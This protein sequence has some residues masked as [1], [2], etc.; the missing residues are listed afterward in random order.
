MERRHKALALGA[1]LAAG[2]VLGVL[3]ALRHGQKK[4]QP[5][6]DELPE[7][8]APHTQPDQGPNVNPVDNPSP[9]SE[10]GPVLD[11]LQIAL[12]ED[13]QDWDDLGCRG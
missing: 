6:E 9:A 12:A 11:P 5:Q 4:A 3:A 10:N 8:L 1:A 2:A 13:F 7:I